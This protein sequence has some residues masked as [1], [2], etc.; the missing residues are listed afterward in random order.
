LAISPAGQHADQSAHHLGVIAVGQHFAAM[1]QDGFLLEA[2][3]VDATEVASLNAGF[4]QPEL[5]LDFAGVVTAVG[6][7]V[8]DHKVGDRVAGVSPSGCWG[9]FVTCDA[10]LAAPIPADLSAEAAAA[11]ATAYATAW[12]GLHDLA[13]IAAGDRVLIHSATGGVGQAAIAIAR[14]AGAEIF[15]TAGSPARRQL[16]RDMGITH[17]YDSRT[18]DFADE[19]R[20]DT[21]GYGVDVVLNSLIGTP[22]LVATASI[23]TR[24]A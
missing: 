11:V 20:Q 18:T 24:L 13:R 22:H 12:F 16:L 7:C 19:I 9:T 6:P 23:N 21:D 5:G 15:A 17:V 14:Q 8:A 4:R 2:E 10:R 3:R 1:V